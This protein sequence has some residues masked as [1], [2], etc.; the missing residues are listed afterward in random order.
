[1]IN[2]KISVY[3]IL[4]YDLG[5][6]D[7]IIKN[8][9]NFVDEIIII[10]GPY[11]YNKEIFQKLNLYYNELNKP[12]ELTKIIE[13]YSD[14]IK[15][16]YK[17]F[18]N[19]EDKRITGYNKCKNDII[20]LIDSD[21]IFILNE[22]KINIF[23][24]STKNVAGLDIY[25]MNRINL[26]FDKMVTKYVMFKKKYITDIEHLDYLWLVGCKQNEKK[27][28][29]MYLEDRLGTIYHQTLNRTKFNNIIK[30]IFYICLYYYKKDLPINILGSYNLDYLLTLIS[31]DELLDIFYHTS[32]E[33]IGIPTDKI[34]MPINVTANLEK[35][36]FNHLNGFLKNDALCIKNIPYYCYLNINNSDK[37]LIEFENVLKIQIDLYNINENEKYIINT[38]FFHVENNII[39][40]D[41]K[42]IKKNDNS[43]LVAMFNCIETKNNFFYKVIKLNVVV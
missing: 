11:L 9:Y 29:Y 15:Y 26:A 17:E 42:F 27:I 41:Y 8:V 23:I 3:I 14:K 24:N 10:D 4:Y 40:I 32:K 12:P 21:E 28:D 1:M 25:N 35:Y 31:I 39:T 22:D 38:Y 19:E 6:L 43:T 37:I 34:L 2:E 16:F 30:Y 36:K 5:F 33:F 7:D 20:L 13:K 18:E